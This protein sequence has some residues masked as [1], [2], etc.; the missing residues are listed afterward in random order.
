MHI[1]RILMVSKEYFPTAI[2]QTWDHL[3]IA[4]LHTR[5]NT[6][7]GQIFQIS[8]AIDSNLDINA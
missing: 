3:L 8:A 6:E 5:S 1:Y 7:Q 4:S 2:L